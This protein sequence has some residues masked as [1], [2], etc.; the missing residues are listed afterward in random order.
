M[1]D[2]LAFG[3]CR[4]TASQIGSSNS[5]YGNSSRN[6]QAASLDRS[7]V[8]EPLMPAWSEGTNIFDSGKTSTVERDTGNVSTRGGRKRRRSYADVVE[9]DVT[10][11]GNECSDV[12]SKI[13]TGGHR[14]QENSSS[15][16]ATPGDKSGRGDEEEGEVS[17]A[18]PRTVSEVT[19][20]DVWSQ[21]D[22]Y[23]HRRQSEVARA[24]RHVRVI[25]AMCKVPWVGLR[26]HESKAIEGRVA[27]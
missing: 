26:L 16:T 7:E 13:G 11:R 19:S 25:D 17:E 8:T 24:K 1:S 23:V 15:E 10:C 21:L 14:T 4:G 22:S 2:E 12:S 3:Q 20:T 27:C 5:I 9:G 6:S 18:L